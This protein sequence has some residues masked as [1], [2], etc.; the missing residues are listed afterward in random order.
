[1]LIQQSVRRA[2]RIG[3]PLLAQAEQMA[4]TAKARKVASFWD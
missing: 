3:R 4:G 1:M 2:Q